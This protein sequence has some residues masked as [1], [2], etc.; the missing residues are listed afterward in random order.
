MLIRT[1]LALLEAQT[2]NPIPRTEALLWQRPCDRT[3]GLGVAAR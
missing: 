3:A 1:I 2:D